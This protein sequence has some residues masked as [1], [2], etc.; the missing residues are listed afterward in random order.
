MGDNNEVFGVY[1]HAEAT[2]DNET[3]SFSELFYE[4]VKSSAYTGYTTEKQNQA[5]KKY[6]N[7][8]CVTLH[9]NRYEDL[10]NFNV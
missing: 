6:D 4:Y 5:L 10:Y 2:D 9:E 1:N 8:A 7:E 3:G